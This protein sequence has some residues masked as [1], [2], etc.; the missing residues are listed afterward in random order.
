MD[1]SH[2]VPVVRPGKA[3]RAAHQ[4][5]SSR[6]GADGPVTERD[7]AVAHDGD[8][9]VG[10]RLR[11]GVGRGGRVGAGLALAAVQVAS[12]HRPADR[13]GPEPG[14]TASTNGAA[15]ARTSWVGQP[16]SSFGRTHWMLES[17][18][19]NREVKGSSGVVRR[20]ERRDGASDLRQSTLEEPSLGRRADEA[21]ARRWAVAA[22]STAPACGAGQR[23]RSGAVVVVELAVAARRWWPGRWRSIDHRAPRPPRSGPRPASPCGARGVVEGWR[24]SRCRPSWGDRAGIGRSRPRAVGADRGRSAGDRGA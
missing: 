13:H 10:R 16:G 12:T 19:A 20:V 17:I 3:S 21:S 15:T 1:R 5:A 6:S 4:S 22:S 9:P 24:A 7:E 11:C 23:G 18:D 14:P 2:L 8:G